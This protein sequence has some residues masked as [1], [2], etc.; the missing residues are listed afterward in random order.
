MGTAVL[1]LVSYAPHH[2]TLTSILTPY[3]VLFKNSMTFVKKEEMY[4]INWSTL[5]AVVVGT[6]RY[7]NGI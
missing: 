1:D 2:R 5:F 3:F 7:G 4:I 6:C